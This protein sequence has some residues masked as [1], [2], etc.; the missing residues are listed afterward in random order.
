MPY[1]AK[2]ESTSNVAAMTVTQV[3][4][5]DQAF[6]DT[7]SGFWVQTSYNTYGNQH[8]NGGIPLRGNFAGLGFYYDIEKDAFIPPAP[9][10]GTWILNED[11]FLWEE[12][13]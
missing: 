9:E 11:T 2:C 7:Q 6:V 1:F 10:Q 3:I 13:N 8:Y 5:A 12:S 4:A